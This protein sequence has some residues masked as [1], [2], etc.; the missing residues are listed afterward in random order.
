VLEQAGQWYGNQPDYFSRQIDQTM[1]SAL[2]AIDATN[3]NDAMA[4]LLVVS[5]KRAPGAPA[6]DLMLITPNLLDVR[7]KPLK[8]PLVDLLVTIS[9]NELVIEGIR[10]RLVELQSQYPADLSITMT[11]AVYELLLK[12]GKPD[13]SLE[14]LR[15][16]LSSHKLE[17]LR[18]G[19]RANSRQRREAMAEI[20]LWF[21]A[22]E[23]LRTADRRAM[24]AE[25]A[26][27]AL[28][29][30][31]RQMGD[32]YT[33]TI[34]YEWGKLALEQGDRQEAEAKWTELLDIV[35]RR[36]ERASKPEP[37][38]RS[39]LEPPPANR[40]KGLA[41]YQSVG[42]KDRAELV[43][44]R[45]AGKQPTAKTAPA[46][47]QRIPPLTVS[48]FRLTMEIALAAADSGV[49]AWFGCFTGGDGGRRISSQGHWQM[50]R[51]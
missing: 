28:A 35:T 51:R 7:T 30:A 40:T 2:A 10:K 4:Q 43:A 49:D 11:Q 25:I 45:T 48:Q 39:A 50:A 36:P 1:N 16:I 13:A 44:Q 3:A 14:A 41:A 22:R 32:L 19:R 21:I 18:A 9:K 8:S 33:A 29:A 5:E 26:Q 46:A 34:L 6:L 23:C 20:P 38:A 17:E 42:T 12:G 37:N 15:G 27:R 47:G 31:R 24:G